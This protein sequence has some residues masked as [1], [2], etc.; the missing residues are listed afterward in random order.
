MSSVAQKGKKRK[1][2]VSKRL[3]MGRRRAADIARR[4]RRREQDEVQRR[5]VR[6]E[7]F[8]AK[9]VRYYRGLRARMPEQEA[10]EKTLER[11]RPT[12][13]WH[14]P[15][16]ASSIRRWHRQVAAEGWESLRGQS[17]RP[18]TIHYQV[19]EQVVGI[20]FMLRTML[21]WGGHRI[22]RELKARGIA[23]VTGQT[24]YRIFD[25]LG[26]SVQRYALKGR[27]DGIAYRRYEKQRPNQQ[28]HIDV[29]E[30]ALSDGTK[31]Y[32]CILVDD[33]SR[34]AIA[35]VVGVAFT[36][37]WVTLVVQGAL[38]RAGQP[39]EI[40][41]DNGRQFISVWEEVL[42]KFGRLL[43]D[44]GIAHRT[45]APYYPQGN[46]KAE[47]FIHTLERELL[48][49]R[50]FATVEELQAG[51]EQYLTFY[52]NYRLHSSLEWQTPVSRYAGRALAVRGLAG[53]PGLEQMAA[54]PCWGASGCDPPVVITP[55]T[56]TRVLP[57]EQY[58]PVWAGRIG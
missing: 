51:V 46:G 42:T 50:S 28:W 45:C 31:V 18:H 9:V 53:L 56:A 35:A 32:I 3:T 58:D 15:V 16:S 57:L 24:V 49:R 36:T 19:S 34:Y 55:Q 4:A 25:R 7:R 12:E 39:E 14:F 1:P 2:K 20:I 52:N 8:R 6:Q 17:T 29:K 48:S 44:L 11:W 40:V 30:T 5:G 13:P 38:R 43:A 41:S 37:D 27:S 33:Y 26:L 54:S 22:A 10:I 21:G 47:A 23:A